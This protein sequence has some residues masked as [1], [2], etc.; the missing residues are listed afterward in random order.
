MSSA[1]EDRTASNNW[2]AGDSAM[3]G[4]VFG[5]AGTLEGTLPERLRH[6]SRGCL[7][8]WTATPEADTRAT[9]LTWP[10]LSRSVFTLKRCSHWCRERASIVPIACQA[11][12]E[13]A[14]FRGPPL[15]ERG[16]MGTSDWRTR[17]L[18]FGTRVE[19]SGAPPLLIAVIKFCV[20]S[21]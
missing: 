17:G 9:A 16:V 5:E 21:A 1:E 14:E 6:A 13:E 10:D 7:A 20:Y 2:N 4:G 3:C 15:E 19:Q 11:A 8:R 18:A 12:K